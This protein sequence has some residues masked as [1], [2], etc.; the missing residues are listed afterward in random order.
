ML[1]ATCKQLNEE[2]L[3]H[4]KNGLAQVKDQQN[5]R[6]FYIKLI[7]NINTRANHAWEA[8]GFSPILC[9]SLLISKNVPY[10]DN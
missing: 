7:E 1:P 3:M 8:Y 6:I 9:K 5:F 10:F 4:V 2:I